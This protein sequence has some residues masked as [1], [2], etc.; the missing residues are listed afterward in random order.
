M[1]YINAEKV[2]PREL[3]D[4]I[5]QYVSGKAIYIPSV[6]KKSWG[7]QTG[8]KEYL[9]KRNV[10]IYIEYKE[11]ASIDELANDYALSEKSIKRIIRG[12]RKSELND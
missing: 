1:S 8:T 9:H 3:I 2:L 6:G 10:Q 4:I 12:I 5:Q 7:S 11:G